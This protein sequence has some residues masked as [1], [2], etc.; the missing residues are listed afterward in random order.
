MGREGIPKMF[1]AVAL[2]V[3]SAC[4]PSPAELRVRQMQAAA[5]ACVK[6]GFEFQPDAN[7]Y[8]VEC[9]DMFP[10]QAAFV[11]QIGVAFALRD[12]TGVH[13]DINSA[14]SDGK[15]KFTLYPEPKR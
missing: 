9:P 10:A 4:S 13:I 8:I 14:V 15:G 1:G 2:G 7:R 3:L 5:E 11:D 6:E 12:A